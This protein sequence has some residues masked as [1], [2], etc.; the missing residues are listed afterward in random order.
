MFITDILNEYQARYLKINV[1]IPEV[2]AEVDPD[3]DILDLD[4]GPVPEGHILDHDLGKIIYYFNV[5]FFEYGMNS[6]GLKSVI[7]I[8]L[9]IS[10]R[11]K[12][13]Y[14]L[15]PKLYL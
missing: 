8:Y 14:L 7:I 6:D 2:I 10:L 13:Y 11:Y 1:L 5:F 9:Y 4:L 3:P 15:V 12:H